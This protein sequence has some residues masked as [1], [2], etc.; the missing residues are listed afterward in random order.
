MMPFKSNKTLLLV[1]CFAITILMTV[2]LQAQHF[3]GTLEITSTNKKETNETLLFIKKDRLAITG[4]VPTTGQMNGVIDSEKMLLRTDERDIIMMGN[5]KTA[6]QV[7][8]EDLE[9]MMNMLSGGEK[10]KVKSQQNITM[11]KTNEKRKI[12]G[13]TAVKHIIKDDN[14]QNRE[15]HLWSTND[16]NI[17]W[18][19]YFEAFGNLTSQL[20]LEEVRSSYNW[21]MKST[22]LLIQT[23]VNG[24]LTSSI[25]VNSINSRKLHSDEIDIPQGY[26]LMSFFQMMMR[27]S[28]RQN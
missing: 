14:K 24:E 1:L 22:P 10:P 25:E 16:L 8:L 3:E 12:L 11:S 15:V 6:V 7:K 20:G 28:Q 23:F 26:E 19:T 27:N 18:N 4:K 5:D 9:S 17:D 21:D 2:S 13:Y